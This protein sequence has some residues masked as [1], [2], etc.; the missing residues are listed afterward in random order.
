MSL[1]ALEEHQPI[2]QFIAVGDW[3]VAEPAY[4]HYRIVRVLKSKSRIERMS[5]GALQLMAANLDYLW[6][7]TSANDEFNFKRLQRYLAMA[8]KFNIEPVII[9]TKLD[10]CSNP[11]FYLEQIAGLNVKSVHAVA[12][13][14]PK[15]YEQ[16]D[17]YYISGKTIAMVGS[18][19]VGKSTLINMISN[20]NQPTK[21]IRETDD[22]GRHTTTHRELFYCRNNVAIIDTPGMRELHL[23]ETKDGIEKT[24]KDIT[25]L[26]ANCKF[27]DCNHNSEPGCAINK[28]L[29]DGVIGAEYY[30]N[31]QKIMLEDSLYQQK[32]TATRAIKKTYR[33]IVKR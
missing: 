25:A 22:K 18:S 17:K 33:N 32:S 19:G 1:I 4:E 26:I 5:K 2:S 14:D 27:N 16:L 3:V 11:D 9:L 30:A 13:P 28:A 10:L 20:T 24:F 8:H 12:Q 31:Y 23:T 15:T 21:D 29:E 7:V 6:I